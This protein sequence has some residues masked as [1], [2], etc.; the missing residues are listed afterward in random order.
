MLKVLS[1]DK[2]NQCWTSEL[3]EKGVQKDK[4]KTELIEKGVQ[5]DKRNQRWTTELIEKGV[6]KD[7][8]NQRWTTELV[9][10]NFASRTPLV[11][12][13]TFAAIGMLDLG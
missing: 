2:R 12:I 7:K 11:L 5:K 9:M 3:I 4:R 8:R 13:S 6:Q 1:K 10:G